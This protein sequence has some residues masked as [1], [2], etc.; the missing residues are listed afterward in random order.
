MV[1]GP[2]TSHVSGEATKLNQTNTRLELLHK[3]QDA[4]HSSRWVDM[5]SLSDWKMDDVRS[6]I[7][8]VLRD[9]ILGYAAKEKVSF[10]RIA[11]PLQLGEPS[12]DQWNH[13]IPGDMVHGI[14]L[15]P[16][17]DLLVLQYTRTGK[18]HTEDRFE[19]VTRRF[20][21]AE[22]LLRTL[23]TNEP[24]PMA[25]FERLFS[26]I[27][28]NKY[29]SLYVSVQVEGPLLWCHCRY[30]SSAANLCIW[31]WQTGC[32]VFVRGL[33]SSHRLFTNIVFQTFNGYEHLMPVILSEDLVV[34]PSEI[35]EGLELKVFQIPDEM[36]GQYD[37]DDNPLPIARFGLPPP[38][39]FDPFHESTV[40]LLDITAEPYRPS[41]IPPKQ[42]SFGSTPIFTSD[43]RYRFLHLEFILQTAQDSSY[44]DSR[45]IASVD[46]LLRNLESRMETA[47]S[48][49]SA[50]DPIVIRWDEWIPK[51]A[52]VMPIHTPYCCATFGTV[53]FDSHGPKMIAMRDIS[54]RAVSYMKKGR[55]QGTVQH[56]ADEKEDHANLDLGSFEPSSEHF[57]GE[58]LPFSIEDTQGT[59]PVLEMSIPDIPSFADAIKADLGIV[60]GCKDV[61]AAKST[62]A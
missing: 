43:S 9:G 24:H 54:P 7:E 55:L 4:L 45:I 52:E 12:F 57:E 38:S 50:E 21:Y 22:L 41:A 1:D 58:T 3:Y 44:H 29:A 34:L 35:E 33:S 30:G 47:S 28:Y 46:T 32:L 26:T 25:Y 37:R 18:E 62:F 13:P 16:S 49:S 51:Q 31:N 36:A 56:G 15:D 10:M 60:I 53:S 6:E 2:R 40:A 61:C 17:A 20:N 23:S 19:H 39:D 42:R 59:R 48:D 14:A 8:P 11:S 5:P 27:T